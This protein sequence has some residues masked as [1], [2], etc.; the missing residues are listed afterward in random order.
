MRIKFDREDARQAVVE[1][2]DNGPGIA[3]ELLPDILFEPFKTRKEGG[4]GIG[5]WQVKRVVTSLGGT[6]SA[7][8]KL[9][10]GATVCDQAASNW[11]CRIILQ[12]HLFDGC[13]K[14]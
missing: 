13:I 10:G 1:I 14:R 9:D 2:I 3:T 6:I 4:S 5:L 8:N 7:D 11:R 12:F